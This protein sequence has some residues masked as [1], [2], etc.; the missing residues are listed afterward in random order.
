[1]SQYASERPKNVLPFDGAARGSEP[2]DFDLD[3][4][5]QA[6][7]TLLQQAAQAA[8]DNEERAAAIARKLSAQVQAAEDRAAQLED[9]VRHF[10]DRAFRAEEWLLRIFKEIE[11]QFF[12]QNAT[13]KAGQFAQR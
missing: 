4:S 11:A 8:R 13:V 9:E 12:D 5:G 3:R 7:V 10:Q 2:D 6:I 1:M